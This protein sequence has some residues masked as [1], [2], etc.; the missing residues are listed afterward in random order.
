MATA[1]RPRPQKAK[2]PSYEPVLELPPLPPEQYEALRDHIAVHGVLVPILVDGDGP[3]RGVI[4]GN[5]RKRIADELGYDCPE[6]VKE[7]L[8]DQEKRT[9]ARALNLAR[10]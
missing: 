10:R 2:T 9:L 1:P 6:I 3:V 7:G 4:D 8:T 5:H